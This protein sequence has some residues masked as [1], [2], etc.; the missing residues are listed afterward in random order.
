MSNQ[1]I[2]TI[3]APIIGGGFIWFLNWL[4]N[5]LTFYRVIK[6]K[7]AKIS[8][9]YSSSETIDLV[10]ENK[11]IFEYVDCSIGNFEREDRDTYIYNIKLKKNKN[12]YKLISYHKEG[13]I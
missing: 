4:I 9:F 2:L 12:K 7:C 11:K 8:Y 5:Y 13:L 10:I 3:L 6:I 1:F